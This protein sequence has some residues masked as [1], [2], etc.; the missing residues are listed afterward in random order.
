[1]A[2]YITA[3]TDWYYV[4]AFA[5][6]IGFGWILEQAGFSSSRKMASVFYAKDFTVLKVFFTAALTAS[7]DAL[8]SPNRMLSAIDMLNK[9]VSWNT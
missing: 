4:A 3:D 2:P 5:I 7:S 1:M 6:G 8:R 9:K